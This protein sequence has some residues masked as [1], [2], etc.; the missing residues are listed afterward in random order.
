MEMVAQSLQL[1]SK[2]KK[3]SIEDYEVTI[4]I[5]KS[6]P[7]IWDILGQGL[8]QGRFRQVT[9]CTSQIIS[10]PTDRPNLH[11]HRSA[12]HNICCTLTT[13]IANAWYMEEQTISSVISNPSPITQKQERISPKPQERNDTYL[14][15]SHLHWPR[16][17]E[18]REYAMLSCDK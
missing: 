11:G 10:A 3:M 14:S 5:Y 17:A 4:R 1:I 15:V 9:P 12:H 13:L 8:I 7:S 16:Q 18:D 6:E 2:K